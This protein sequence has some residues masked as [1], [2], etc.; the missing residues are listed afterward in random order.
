V[1]TNSWRGS[2]LVR[3]LLA[4]LGLGAGRDDDG[5]GDA[6]LADVAALAGGYALDGAEAVLAPAR[7]GLRVRLAET[8]PVSGARLTRP[9]ALARPLGGGVFGF[10]GGV[11]VSHRL[12]FPRAGIGR[13]GWVAMPRVSS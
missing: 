3:R 9:P 13:F 2:V 7:G 12:D 4:G 8:E 5:S 11:L 10:G 1:L 6:G